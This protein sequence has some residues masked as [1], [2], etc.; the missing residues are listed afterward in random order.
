MPCL[1]NTNHKVL[2]LDY[3]VIKQCIGAIKIWLDDG[4]KGKAW[5]LQSYYSFS[6]ENPADCTGFH[7]ISSNNCNVVDWLTD[8]TS[9]ILN[10]KLK[11]HEGG[12]QKHWDEP[13]SRAWAGCDHEGA[14]AEKRVEMGE[15]EWSGWLDGW[16]AEPV[17]MEGIRQD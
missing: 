6:W 7:D 2:V 12:L 8:Q 10:L 3:F 14:R 4:V 1:I 15:A 13:G 11:E 16:L 9:H 17:T 5:D